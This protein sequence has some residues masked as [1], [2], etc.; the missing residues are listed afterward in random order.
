[1]R[2]GAAISLSRCAADAAIE[3]LTRSSRR[4]EP[5]LNRRR[6]HA[7]RAKTDG[8]MPARDD[9]ST[10]PSRHVGD[11]GRTE[12]IGSVRTM[13]RARFRSSIH[14]DSRRMNLDLLQWPAMAATIIAAWLVAS[15]QKRRRKA[16]FWVYLAS[17]VLWVAWGL[18]D[19][20]YALIA[21]QF[22]LAAMNF[23]GVHKNEPAD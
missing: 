15:Q 16:G 2:R 5:A 4:A 22:A 13:R 21:L 14:G 19:Q 1:M 20:A 23:R 9:R 3:P 18:H 6:R 11:A 10:R 17:N 12:C 7:R 8:L